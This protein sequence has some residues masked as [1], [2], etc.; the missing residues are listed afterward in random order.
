[1]LRRGS[2]EKERR[3]I[4][5]DFVFD[6]E[7]Q[8]WDVF[9]VGAIECACHGFRV[10]EDEKEFVDALLDENGVGWGHN[11]GKYDTLLALQNMLDRQNVRIFNAGSRVICVKLGALELRDS[12]AL[13]PMSLKQASEIGGMRKLET[14]LPCVCWKGCGGYCSIRRDMPRPLFNRLVEY[15]RVDC[16]ALRMILDALVAFAEEHDLDLGATIGASA[17][18]NVMRFSDLGPADWSNER[19]SPSVLYAFARLAYAGGMTRCFRPVVPYGDVYDINSAYPAALTQINLPTGERDEIFGGLAAKAYGNER[20]G[21]YQARVT[22]HPDT[23]IPFLMMKTGD[24]RSCYP[25][26]TFTGQWTLPELQYA[27]SLGVV[28]DSIERAIVWSKAQALLKAWCEKIW[29]LRDAVGPKSAL[30]IWLKL[31]ANSLTGKLAQFP[32]REEVILNPDAKFRLCPRDGVCMGLLCGSASVGCCPHGCTGACGSA[33]PIDRNHRIWTKRIYRISDC[34]HVHFSAYLTGATRITLHKMLERAGWEHAAYCDTDSIVSSLELH[35]LFPDEIGSALGQWKHE[36]RFFEFVCIAPKTYAMVDADTGEYIAK[37]K[38]IPDAPYH[39]DHLDGRFG[40]VTI[41]RG[42]NTFRTAVRNGEGLF[43]RKKMWRAL[44]ADGVR[45]G[46]RLL[47]T[48]GRT[49][50]QDYGAFKPAELPS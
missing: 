39:F 2:A 29:A 7:T 35:K 10:F 33:K 9:V 38:G 31:Y 17:W 50:P 45:F 44:S 47:H 32:E 15:L 13:I 30:G 3:S 34:A 18:R 5:V 12:A 27:E 14:G 41:D 23:Y 42:V 28:I 49:Y 8:D 36:R 16:K 37:A 25:T 40:G 11:A 21:L 22:V 48:D 19:S 43:K 24:G 26:G 20:P 6:I 1:M 4:A 46:D